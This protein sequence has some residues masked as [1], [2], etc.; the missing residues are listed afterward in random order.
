MCHGTRRY[1]FAQSACVLSI[2]GTTRYLDSRFTSSVMK[3]DTVTLTLLLGA[4]YV[5]IKKIWSLLLFNFELVPSST[6]V[7]GK[8]AVGV[9]RSL[10]SSPIQHAMELASEKPNRRQKYLEPASYRGIYINM[11]KRFCEQTSEFQEN[12]HGFDRKLLS[13]QQSPNAVPDCDNIS[14][15][16]EWIRREVYG[17]SSCDNFW[18]L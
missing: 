10:V 18:V 11:L 15:Q 14:H 17:G 16:V 6:A 1:L 4:W 5:S 9:Q 12:R 7:L 13:Q 3:L 2:R 8:C